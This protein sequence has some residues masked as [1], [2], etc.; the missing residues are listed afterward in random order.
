MLKNYLKVLVVILSLFTIGCQSVNVIEQESANIYTQF[1][2]L[3]YAEINDLKK[4]EFNITPGTQRLLTS[5]IDSPS[6][7]VTLPKNAE[8][9][10]VLVRSEIN[11]SVFPPTLLFL[12]GQ[13]QLTAVISFNEFEY[14]RPEAFR[15]DALTYLFEVNSIEHK[16]YV[17][18]IIY[19]TTEDLE[20]FSYAIHPERLKAESRNEELNIE[21]IKVR[22]S[23]YGELSVTLQQIARD[24]TASK[25]KHAVKAQSS[26]Y[27]FGEIEK[28]VLNGDIQGALRVRDEAKYYGIEGADAVLSEAMQN[29]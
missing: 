29:K 23:E 11:K 5:D 22:H 8:G 1:S 10:S 13:W 15:G 16:D 27:Y 21:D 4:H 28:Y 20:S 19:T 26:D 14:Q 17:H 2:D 6:I 3:D 25:K 12:D 24:S 18:M 7:G 9:I